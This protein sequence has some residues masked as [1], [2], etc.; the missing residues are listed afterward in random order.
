MAKH[1]VKSADIVVDNK[2][3][4]KTRNRELLLK[5]GNGLDKAEE[6]KEPIRKTVP[7]AAMTVSSSSHVKS[8]KELGSY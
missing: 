8:N 6:L 2:N 4:S 3:V 1:T 5:M 7:N